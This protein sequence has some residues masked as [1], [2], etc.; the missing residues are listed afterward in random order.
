MTK[1]GIK[2]VFALKHQIRSL[3]CYCSQGEAEFNHRNVVH[4][5]QKW[6]NWSYRKRPYSFLTFKMLINY[7]IY[8]NQVTES[9]TLEHVPKIRSISASYGALLLPVFIKIG[10]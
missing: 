8:H 5:T 10:F 3:E 9:G 7:T 2:S 6:K 1:T 4:I